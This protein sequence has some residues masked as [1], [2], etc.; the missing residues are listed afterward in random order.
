VKLPGDLASEEDALTVAVLKLF[1]GHGVSKA[2][3]RRKLMASA[4]ARARRD[5]HVAE[6]VTLMLDSRERQQDATLAPV[7][8]MRRR[9]R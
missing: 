8:P 7:I 3:I 5:P 6:L 9:S 2:A 1:A 4:C